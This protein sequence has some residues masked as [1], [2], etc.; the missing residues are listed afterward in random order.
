MGTSDVLLSLTREQALVLFE[1]LTREDEAEKIPIAHPSEQR[2]LWDLQAM[3]EKSL[4][5]PFA[6]NYD[7]IL[8][9]ARARLM[10]EKG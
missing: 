1:W 6:S 5:E 10:D 4:A 2:V 8:A 7:E 3:L 9:A